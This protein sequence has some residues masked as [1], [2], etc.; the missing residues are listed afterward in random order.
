MTAEK[1]HKNL[2]SIPQGGREYKRLGEIFDSMLSKIS[3]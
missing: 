1:G 3:P 2:F